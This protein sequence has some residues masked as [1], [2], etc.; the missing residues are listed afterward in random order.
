MDDSLPVDCR[1]EVDS[2]ADLAAL[3]V[4]DRCVP[5]A[6]RDGCSPGDY[7]PE[8]GCSPADSSLD[9]CSARADSAGADIPDWVDSSPVDSVAA[10][11]VVAGYS[12][13]CLAAQTADDHFAPAAQMDDSFPAAA[14]YRVD[15]SPDDCWRADSQAVGDSQKDYSCPAVHSPQ[16][17]FRRADSRVELPP[18]ATEPAWLAE[19]LSLE[20]QRPVD[21]PHASVAFAA[22][23]R[24]LPD[25]AAVLA[26]WLQR[27][28]VAAAVH[29]SR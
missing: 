19:R 7:F 29:S 18:R 6:G 21:L 9:D 1:A 12:A 2:R 28:A 27:T 17:D 13:G 25:Y 4:G 3:T 23:A 8:A 20:E 5:A 14:D 10:D 11:W 22:A 24:A 16:A 26:V 15:S